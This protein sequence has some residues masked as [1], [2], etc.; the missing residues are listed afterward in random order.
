MGG[1][2]KNNQNDKMD[3]VVILGPMWSFYIICL[4]EM[5]SFVENDFYVI[6]KFDLQG[7]HRGR[8]MTFLRTETITG[9][10]YLVQIDHF[11]KIVI[12]NQNY[13]GNILFWPKMT[14]FISSFFLDKIP[15]S[16]N[17]YFNQV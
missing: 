10:F 1:G 17:G 6:V 9:L 4:N 11:M 15:A 16:V 14:I 2:A 7:H 12:S 3:F 13:P 5:I 8:K